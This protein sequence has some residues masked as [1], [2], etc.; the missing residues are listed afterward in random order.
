MVV[1]DLENRRI[2]PEKPKIVHDFPADERRRV[3]Y[4]EGY[5]RIMVNGEVT[6]ED[7]NC[8]WATPGH[9]LRHGRA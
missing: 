5:R 6:F 2:T 7:G 4:A 8:T 3:Q 9:L 1:Y